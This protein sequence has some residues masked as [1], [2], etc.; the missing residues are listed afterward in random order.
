MVPGNKPKP[1]MP[2]EEEVEQGSDPATTAVSPSGE[3]IDDIDPALQQ[4]EVI[5]EEP[6]DEEP[7]DDEMIEDEGPD[8]PLGASVLRR[9]H[10][11]HSIL[12]QDY[13]EMVQLVEKEDVTNH[14]I[15]I[16][17]R[18]EEALSTT[19]QLFQQL[20]NHLPGIEGAMPVQQEMMDGEDPNNPEMDEESEYEDEGEEFEEGDEPLDNSEDGEGNPDEADQ[21]AEGEEP[22]SEEV[23]VEEE[24]EKKP[25][26]EGKS[27]KR[28]KK[29]MDEEEKDM[30]TNDGSTGADEGA[31]HGDSHA[32]ATEGINHGD[33]SSKGL[34]DHEKPILHEAHAFLGSLA[35]EEGFGEKQRQHCF[36]FHKCLGNMCGGG[37][38]GKKSMEGEGGGDVPSPEGEEKE[39][40]PHRQACGVLSDFFGHLSQEK[41]FGEAHRAKCME[42][43]KSLSSMLEEKHDE[44]KEGTNKEEKDKEEGKDH[45]EEVGKIGEKTI[46]EKVPYKEAKGKSLQNQYREM[47][48]AAE[49]QTKQMSDLNSKLQLLLSR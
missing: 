34:L 1:Q 39:I 14:V 20:Y 22:E 47:S 5:D 10:E 26:I 2:P 8:E 18:A 36:Y 48:V 12:M 42:F 6:L 25:K 40:H 38:S 33:V 44:E 13:H 46:P 9:I 15:D 43:H 11:D 28:R 21:A 23:A 49:E 35:H 32:D 41:A 19:E 31:S 4:E 37:N 7:I 45:Q 24:K 3:P 30:D 27:L 16:L 29:D 17:H